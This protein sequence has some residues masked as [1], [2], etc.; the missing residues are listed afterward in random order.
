MLG[1]TTSRCCA[2]LHGLTMKPIKK[3]MKEVVDIKERGGGRRI[4]RYGSWRSQDL[5]TT[6]AGGLTEDDLCFWTCAR[7]WGRRLRRSKVRKHVDIR[8]FG[9]G[10]WLFKTA[11]TSFMTWTLL[12]YR[13]W[14]QSKRWYLIETF[15]EIQKGK[16]LEIIMY[17][18]KWTL[19]VPTPPV[20]PYFSSISSSY[21]PLSQQVQLPLPP[22]LQRMKN[23]MV[24]Y[25]HLMW[26]DSAS[27]STVSKFICVY[28]CVCSCE[29]LI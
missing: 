21:A 9:I 26:S 15:L 8:Q 1:K 4:L 27:C 29:N 23:S 20:S 2:W 25:F 13:H 11:L 5:I 16:K 7:R 10:H 17:F 24:I 19:S 18:S 14:N 28:L 3:I 6:T 22:P 12:W